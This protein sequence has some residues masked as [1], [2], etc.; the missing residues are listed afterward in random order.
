MGFTR[1]A[2]RLLYKRLVAH[3]YRII[4]DEMSES[5]AQRGAKENKAESVRKA[6]GRKKGMRI[7]DQWDV[8]M[9]GGTHLYSFGRKCN[10]VM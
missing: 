3:G 9:R 4:S 1:P 5:R 8:E 6:R 10:T 7:I 2:L